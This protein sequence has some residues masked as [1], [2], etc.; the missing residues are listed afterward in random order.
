[1]VGKRPV[2]LRWRGSKE[3]IICVID[4]SVFSDVVLYGAMVHD[5][6]QY[7]LIDE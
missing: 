6:F 5:L 3:F 1:M 7:L 2:G 4:F